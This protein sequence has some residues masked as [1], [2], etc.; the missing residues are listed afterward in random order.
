M[1]TSPKVNRGA[2]FNVSS[3]SPVMYYSPGSN[4]YNNVN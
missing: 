2:H 1:P 3:P 4:N